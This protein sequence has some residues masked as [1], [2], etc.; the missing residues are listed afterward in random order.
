MT[1]RMLTA[2]LIPALFG[3]FTVASAQLP[4]KVIADKYLIQAEQLLEKKDYEAVLNLME[5][6]IALQK[7]YGFTLPEEFHFRYAQVTFLKYAQVPVPADSIKIAL[8]SV[9]K[10]LS[11]ET[12]GEFYKE[13]LAL[14]LKIEEKLEELEFSPDKT[15]AGKEYGSCWMELTNQPECYVW[16][17]DLWKDETMAWSGECSGSMA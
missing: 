4:P 8:E 16:N 10:Y 6:I 13:A 3:F 17:P 12:E 2:F 5:K 1:A 9:S 11:A 7:E 14:L 15:C